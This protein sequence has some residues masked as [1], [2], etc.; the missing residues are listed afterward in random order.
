MDDRDYFVPIHG[1]KPG[2]I[3]IPQGYHILV[4]PNHDH[5]AQPAADAA[6]YKC[7]INPKGWSSNRREYYV[8]ADSTS[9]ALVKLFS[10][11]QLEEKNEEGIEITKLVGA[12]NVIL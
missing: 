3:K 1:Q 10:K 12:D 4:H 5:K 7:T 8:V 6:L 9:A 11:I 2:F